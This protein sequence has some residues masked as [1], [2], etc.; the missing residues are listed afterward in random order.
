MLYLAPPAE[1]I[2]LVFLDTNVDGLTQAPIADA[3]YWPG[4]T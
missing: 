4:L 3:D 2:A 1:D